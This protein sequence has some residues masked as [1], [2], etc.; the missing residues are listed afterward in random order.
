MATL[1]DVAAEAGVSH[2]TVSRVVN[3]DPTVR[4]ATKAKVDAAVAKLTYRPSLTARA[5]ASRRTKSIGLI[6]TG[7]PFYGPSSTMHGFNGAARRA[8]YQVSTATLDSADPAAVRQAVDALVGQNVAAVVLI[9][10][11]EEALE[12]LRTAGVSVPL[13]TADSVAEEGHHT[14]SI[15]QAAG[16]EIAVEHLAALGHRRIGHVAGPS[17]WMDGRDRERGWRDASVRLGLDAGELRHGDWTPGSGHALARA[18]VDDGAFGPGGL[19]ALFC[20]ND[21]MALGV[22]HALTAAGLDVPGDVSIVGFDD[23]PEAE[24]F[25]PPLTTVRQDFEAL[26]RRIMDAV[27]C[28]LAGRQPPTDPMAP[29]FVVR[30]STASPRG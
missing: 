15:D 29:E 12:V 3:G 21:Q 6:S 18:L 28:V 16:A 4:P 5:L 8:G 9:A 11:D 24:H 23:I 10:P 17:A 27:E 7:F 30:R 25:L 22:V 19:T 2:Q 1:F 20:A 13:V 14:V 26:G